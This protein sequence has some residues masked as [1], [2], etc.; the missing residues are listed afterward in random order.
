MAIVVRF[1]SGSLLGRDFEFGKDVIRVGDDPAADVRINP[2]AP[3]DSGA[4]NRVIEVSRVGEKFRIRSTGSREISAQGE[5]SGERVLTAGEEIRFGAWGPIFVVSA[6]SDEAPAGEIT[7][8]IPALADETASKKKLRTGPIDVRTLSGERPVGP[9]TVYMMIQDALGKAR[10]TDGG[11]VQRGTVFIREMVGDTIDNAT[12]SLKIGLA[13]LAAAFAIVVVAFALKLAQTSRDVGNVTQ[14]AERKVTAVREELGSEVATLKQE[15]AA[16]AK[17]TGAL[18]QRLGDL[19]KETG[20]DQ[21]RSAELRKQIRDAEERRAALEG[22]LGQAMAALEAQKK[23]LAEQRARFERAEAE[24]KAAEAEAARKAAEAEAARKAEEERRAA[25]AQ[26]AA[27]A[28][29]SASAA[30]SPTPK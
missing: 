3:D 23:E 10:E 8:P 22:R 25:E 26:A 7:A 4:R 19:E 14:T 1:L 6:R 20:V 13:L 16:L 9:K 27:Q 30:T 18:T 5:G 21:K 2:D 17:E 15:R 28:A 12:R 24:R 11:T 29:A